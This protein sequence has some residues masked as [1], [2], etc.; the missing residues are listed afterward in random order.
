MGGVNKLFCEWSVFVFW[1]SQQFNSLNIA[2]NQSNKN[3]IKK[4]VATLFR[5]NKVDMY[6]NC[7]IEFS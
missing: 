2:V 7:T 5:Y 4:I 1:K 6:I 3:S